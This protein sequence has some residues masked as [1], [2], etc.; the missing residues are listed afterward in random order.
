MSRITTFV[1]SLA[2]AMPPAAGLEWLVGQ[3]HLG[4]HYEASRIVAF[5]EGASWRPPAEGARDRSDVVLGRRV[6]R[7]V[8][9]L[10]ARTYRR[11]EDLVHA[12]AVAVDA[13][14]GESDETV[15]AVSEAW[16]PTDG[17]VTTRG[18]EVRITL[19]VAIRVLA[20]DYDVVEVEAEPGAGAELVEAT[21]ITITGA[22]ADTELPAVTLA[23]DP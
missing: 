20:S 5:V 22:L 14:T 23:P 1:E 10:W 7:L 18:V 12:V 4:K 11:A 8:L 6:V 2:A 19:D 3:E 16:R 21:S 9:A 13:V 15:S 17:T